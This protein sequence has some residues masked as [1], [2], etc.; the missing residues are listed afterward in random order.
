MIYKFLLCMAYP[1]NAMLESGGKP[2]DGVADGK[3]ELCLL[4]GLQE[5]LN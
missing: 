2:C 1:E 3:E 5:P 4:L